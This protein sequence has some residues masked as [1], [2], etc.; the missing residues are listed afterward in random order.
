MKVDFVL[1]EEKWRIKSEKVKIYKIKMRE[2]DNKIKRLSQKP[3]GDSHMD[4]NK[5]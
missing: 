2:L 3:S 5:N 4:L 1:M